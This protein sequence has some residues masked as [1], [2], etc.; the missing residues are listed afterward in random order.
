MNRLI[1]LARPDM[2]KM[3]WSRSSRYR[4]KS[5]ERTVKEGP[6]GFLEILNSGIPQI[7]IVAKAARN[8]SELPRFKRY[9]RCFEVHLQ[10]HAA[11]QALRHHCEIERTHQDSPSKETSTEPFT[12]FGE[13]DRS[14]RDSI[15]VCK[16]V[17]E[18]FVI[19]RM[20][21]LGDPSIRTPTFWTRS[22]LKALQSV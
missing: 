11:D 13:G 1:Y 12:L 10:A 20:K 17:S 19:I 14:S 9:L 15:Q 3:I 5:A 8:S 22:H 16:K 21:E 4:S 6:G 18:A 7:Q 2:T